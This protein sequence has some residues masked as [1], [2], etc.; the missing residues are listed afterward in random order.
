MDSAET[1]GN[2]STIA[3]GVGLVGA[4]TGVVL[5]LSEDPVK[6]SKIEAYAGGTVAGVRG[7]F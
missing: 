3:F 2:I 6:H 7:R 1:A 4:A 5:L